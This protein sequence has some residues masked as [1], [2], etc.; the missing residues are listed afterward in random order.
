VLLLLRAF[1]SGAVALTG[2]EAISN[3][4][5]YFRPPETRNAHQ[6]LVAL[7]LAFGALFLGIG[8][9]SGQIGIVPDP[10]EVETVHS[11]LTRLILGSGPLHL[12]LEVSALL[13]L[14]LAADTG[15]A[16]FPRLLS[17][18]AR[19]GFL[20]QAFAVR[21]ARLAFSNGIILVAAISGVLIVIFHGSVTLLVPLF[22]VGAFATFTLSQ[23]GMA[24]RWWLRHEPGWHW[25]MVINAV[26]AIVTTVVLVIVVVS[27]FVYGA[28]IVAVLVPLLVMALHAVGVHHD[29]LI[30][31][32]RIGSGQAGARYAAIPMR[33]HAVITVGR[34]DRI[35]LQAVRYA[36]GLNGKIEA[37]HVTDD[38]QHGQQLR[39][40]WDALETGIPLV[41]L[42][43]PIRAHSG[44]LV[45]YLD[46]IQKH[47]DPQ[48]YVTVVLPELLP[49]RWW[50]PMLHN[51]FAWKLKW[52]MLF[53][54]HTAVT[55]VPYE[56]KD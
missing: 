11:Q 29:R 32:T 2:I 40:E 36:R 45:R 22:T 17:L 16:D 19:D 30:R 37:V 26:G 53:R 52:V 55:S 21:G 33:H 44:A 51:Y 56:V 15:F 14:I 43:S 10:T 50:H 35:V 42:E 54:H 9:L 41:I 18:L 38:W 23:A 39:A 28:W 4:V 25:R 13:L 5:P 34:V 49:T 48:C 20:P 6:T 3:G 47:Q 7:A 27:K 46:F 12:I 24:R 31:H 1:S 8:F